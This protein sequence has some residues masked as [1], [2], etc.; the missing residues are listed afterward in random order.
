M[1][2]GRVEEHAEQAPIVPTGHTFFY[3]WIRP[4]GSKPWIISVCRKTSSELYT[5]IDLW[6]IF[7]CASGVNWPTTSA[8]N[9]FT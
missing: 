3:H 4:F 8:S 2:V 7:G 1:L 9:F 6:V 5:T